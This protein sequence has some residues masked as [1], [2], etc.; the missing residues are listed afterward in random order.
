MLIVSE[1]GGTT[2]QGTIQPPEN[3]QKYPD[4]GMFGPMP[5]FGFYVRHVRGLSMSNVQIR[6]IA[7]DARP[8]LVLED[9]Q[10]AHFFRIEAQTAAGSPVF[11]LHQVQNFAIRYSEPVPDTRLPNAENLTLPE[12]R[13]A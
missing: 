5:A 9:V 6:T 4:P 10:N 8:A 1:G 2:Q 3:E 13:M 12:S 7:P 11:S